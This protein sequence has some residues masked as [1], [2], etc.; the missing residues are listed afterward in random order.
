[1]DKPIEQLC[2]GKVTCISQDRVAVL[3]NKHAPDSRNRTHVAQFTIHFC[4]YNKIPKDGYLVEKNW[5]VQGK[6]LNKS[7]YL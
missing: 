7:K 3:W 4:C 2:V 5:W 1:M 6:W